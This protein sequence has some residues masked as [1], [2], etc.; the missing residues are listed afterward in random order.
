MPALIHT[1]EI[2]QI[3]MQTAPFINPSDQLWIRDPNKLGWRQI[4]SRMLGRTTR[5]MLRTSSDAD[6]STVSRNGRALLQHSYW[7]STTEILGSIRVHLDR[8]DAHFRPSRH[9]SPRIGVTF[10][11]AKVGASNPG[12]TLCWS[13]LRHRVRRY[14]AQVRF[15]QHVPVAR[16]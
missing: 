11:P 16:R 15:D 8:T 6:F 13:A 1:W 10:H 7:A 12:G 9:L 14:A 5:G 4:S 2:L 3:R